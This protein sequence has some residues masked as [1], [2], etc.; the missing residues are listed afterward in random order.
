MFFV[1]RE[2][3]S[4][5]KFTY[6]GVNFSVVNFCDSGPC[7]KTYN[8]KLPVISD[9]KK[10]EYNFYYRNDPRVLE[11]LVPF[12]GEI[13]LKKNI[14]MNISYGLSC[15]GYSAVALENFGTLFRVYG[16]EVTPGNA[17][18]GIDSTKVHISLKESNETKIDQISNSCY[19][20]EIKDCEVVMGIERFLY[21]SLVEINKELN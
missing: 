12:N 16:A 13:E 11:T 8:T 19:T 1:L 6:R 9:G 2:N 18:C 7:L 17:E 21:E 5:E 4:E 3:N 20:I 14:S 10:A 15:E